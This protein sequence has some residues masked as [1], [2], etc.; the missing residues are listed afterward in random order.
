MHLISRETAMAIM[1][2]GILK[3]SDDVLADMLESF[4]ESH[5]RNYNI[6][7]M[8]EVEQNDKKEY[9]LP[10]IRSINEF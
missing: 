4:P 7:S 9:P 6:V 10:V 1:I 8:E 2:S 3:V 5:F